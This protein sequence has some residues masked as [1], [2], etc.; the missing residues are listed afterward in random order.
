[1]QL[2]EAC[3]FFVQVTVPPWDHTNRGFRS[4]DLKGPQQKTQRMKF[5][6]HTHTK[7]F[8][9][10][11]GEGGLCVSAAGKH[12]QASCLFGTQGSTSVVYLGKWFFGRKGV[13]VGAYWFCRSTFSAVSRGGFR[14][15]QGVFLV[16]KGGF[17]DTKWEVLTFSPK[18]MSSKFMG[19]G[20]ALV[21]RKFGA[22]HPAFQ[23]GC[24]IF[25]A[26]SRG[27][28]LCLPIPLCLACAMSH[29][30][31]LASTKFPTAK[32]TKHQNLPFLYVNW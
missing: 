23:F 24:Q 13:F 29:F 25:H 22:G 28:R 26:K 14:Y 8:Y 1:M 7:R 11:G 32:L 6:L 17:C 15:K 12:G 4:K 27:F 3:H 2:T 10:A 20:G 18:L 21:G 5:L 16:Q 31:L 9:Q 19:G 30:F